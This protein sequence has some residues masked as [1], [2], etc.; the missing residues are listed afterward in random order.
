MPVSQT[1]ASESLRLVEEAGARSRS[2]RG[3]SLAAPHL[4]LWGGVYFAAYTYGYFRPGQSGLVWTV[5]VPAA[6]IA[7]FVI[8]RR[9]KSAVGAADVGKTGAFASLFATFL[10]FITATAA[11][12]QPNDP[13]QMAAFVPLVV[14]VAYIIL[15]LNHGARLAWT[16]VALG[17]LTLAGYFAL[18]GIFMLW[19]AVVGGGALVAGGLWLRQ[20]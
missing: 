17:V 1:D 8:A 7:D 18:P 6:V 2:L 12:M 4:I 5:A 13:R 3:Y 19:M 9:A 15:G 20:V 14:A 10:A 11:I 16:G